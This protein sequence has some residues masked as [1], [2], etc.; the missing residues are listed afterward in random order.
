MQFKMIITI[1]LLSI[2]NNKCSEENKAID[3]SM[4]EQMYK[5]MCYPGMPFPPL[6]W[7]Y[8]IEHESL[9]RKY[10]VYRPNRYDGKKTAVIFFWHPFGSDPILFY[11]SNTSNFREK[12]NE[13]Y[14]SIVIVPLG[15]Q[16]PG[17]DD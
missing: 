3:K 15:Q 13:K 16:R 4:Y 14:N 9:E 11:E 2:I 1:L 5:D 10:A 7:T 6:S 8:Y 17:G 12:A